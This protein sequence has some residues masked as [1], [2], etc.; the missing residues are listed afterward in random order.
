M[1]TMRKAILLIVLLVASGCM[2][3]SILTKEE[4]ETQNRADAAVSGV[5]F[6]HELDDE[7]SYNCH[8]DGFL[9]IKFADSV[10][11][12][13]YT[14][15]VGILRSNPKV[16]GVRAEQGGKEVCKLTGYR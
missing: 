4:I 12:G 5:L 1:A 7:A 10:P 16:S 14:Q 13:Q 9:V 6:E 11:S 2:S 15:V 8:K 3:Q